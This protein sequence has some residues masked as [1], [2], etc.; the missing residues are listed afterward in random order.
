MYRKLILVLAVASMIS[1]SLMSNRAIA[2]D[3]GVLEL[4][5]DGAFGVT[6]FE[7]STSATQIEFPARFRFGTFVSEKTSIDF[8]MRLSSFDQNSFFDQTTFAF[9]VGVGIHFTEKRTGTMG[10]VQPT[11]GL[12][13]LKIGSF[14]G[15]QFAAGAEIGFKTI[16]SSGLAG[17]FALFA[18]RAFEND[19]FVSST[20]FGFLFG[21]SFFTI[22]R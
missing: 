14:S 5:V 17:R 13:Y 3:R 19:K 12:G 11:V 6:D 16:A 9:D 15:A 10:F 22:N 21:V 4:G 20:T 18:T 8:G 7:F 1:A 2:I